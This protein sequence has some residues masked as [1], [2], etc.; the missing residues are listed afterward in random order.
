[1]DSAL[2]QRLLGAVV[3]IALA[4]IFLPMFFSGSGPKQE[5]ATVNLEIPPAPDREFETRVL[6]VDAASGITTPAPAR[7]SEPVVAVEAPTPARTEAEP[8]TP[9]P[10]PPSAAPPA[11]VEKPPLV[12][13][14]S[15]APAATVP[16]GE[17]AGGKFFVHLGV[18]ASAKNAEDL[19]AALK[20]GGFTAFS[21]TADYQ[22]KSAQRVRV[23][24]YAGR[25]EAEAARMRI[26][27]AKPDV[28][29]SVVALAENAVADAP[30]TAVPAA[31][32]GGWAVQLGAFKTAE[33]ANML[34]GRLQTAGFVAYV[35][36][37]TAEQTLWRVRAGPE[38][39][40]ANADK[41]R[42]RIKDKLKLDG[43][44]VAQ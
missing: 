17:A 27:Q 39:D 20:R 5:S 9:T 11:V 31:R 19:V 25:A 4:I 24:P 42:A 15:A 28:P 2:K 44:I 22:G 13:A 16:A 26:R 35:D 32:A 23:G 33:D 37:L 1:M 18:Y 6:P 10:A 21:E 7:T 29:G 38:T 41:L 34:R 3:L 14:P 8:V 40:R 30:A 43:L 36:K 12:Q